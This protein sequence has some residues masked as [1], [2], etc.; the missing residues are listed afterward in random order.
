MYFLARSL[1]PF[2]TVA[3]CNREQLTL[4][5]PSI[6]IHPHSTDKSLAD[7]PRAFVL[8]L[9]RSYDS[10]LVCQLTTSQSL[11]RRCDIESISYSNTLMI[12]VR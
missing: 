7:V 11:K 5:T 3:C 12:T 8:E 9:R 2:L 6:H 4:S 1:L 10:L